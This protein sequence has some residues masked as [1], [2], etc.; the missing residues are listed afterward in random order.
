[1][2]LNYVSTLHFAT[3]TDSALEYFFLFISCCFLFEMARNHEKRLQEEILSESEVRDLRLFLL[4]LTTHSIIIIQFLFAN[5][6]FFIGPIEINISAVVV[7][8]IV[9]LANVGFC[10]GG[11]AKSLFPA[12]KKSKEQDQTKEPSF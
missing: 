1:M 11:M 10:L 4:A 8:R 9:F 3:Q 5:F 2:A 12:G 6:G 7:Y